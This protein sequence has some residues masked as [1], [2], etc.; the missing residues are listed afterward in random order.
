M[1]TVLILA[2]DEVVAA[3]LGLL[4]ELCG[5]RPVF[6]NRGESVADAC[7][8]ASCEKLVIDCDHWECSQKMLGELHRSGKKIV[9]FSPSRS[10][11][12]TSRSAT[13][14]A[15]KSFTLP[16]GPEAFGKLLA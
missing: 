7:E 11:A 13:P 5:H 4:V 2:R 9:L 10:A 1:E 3:L 16:I 12:E 6:A 8:R 15:L 14:L